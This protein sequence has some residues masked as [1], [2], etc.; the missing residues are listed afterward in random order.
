MFASGDNGASPHLSERDLIPA[1]AVD[2]WTLCAS[3]K[4]RVLDRTKESTDVPVDKFFAMIVAGAIK[5]FHSRPLWERCA[6]LCGHLIA[7][8][9]V[10][11]AAAS[12]VRAAGGTF[13]V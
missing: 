3:L 12:A 8:S 5:K 4:R 11:I 6:V 2:V 10:D 9:D 13:V 7:C 1:V